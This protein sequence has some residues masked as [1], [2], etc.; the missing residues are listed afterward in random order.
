MVKFYVYAYMESQSL[1]KL[2]LQSALILLHCAKNTF[3]QPE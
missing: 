3:T 2:A 1:I